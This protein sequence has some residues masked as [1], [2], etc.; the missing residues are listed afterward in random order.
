MRYLKIGIEI[1]FE[2]SHQNQTAGDPVRNE[3]EVFET[4]MITEFSLNRAP[5]RVNSI[6]HIRP[7]FAV[8]E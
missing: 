5:E 2:V 3:N 1:P 4:M 8:Y 6:I 7:R